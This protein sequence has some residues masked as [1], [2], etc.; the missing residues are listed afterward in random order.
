MGPRAAVTNRLLAAHSPVAC[1]L[2]CFTFPSVLSSTSNNMLS[3][4]VG[5]VYSK[6]ELLTLRLFA[7]L[8]TVVTGSA[9]ARVSSGTSWRERCENEGV[10]RTPCV[11]KTGRSIL[12]K[13]WV[14]CYGGAS[15]QEKDEQ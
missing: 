1:V 6:E 5:V 9:R 10:H 13:G 2:G 4:G 3:I 12:V 15:A 7:S 11:N 14:E 8:A